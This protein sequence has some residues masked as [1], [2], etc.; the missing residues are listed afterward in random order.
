MAVTKVRQN[1]AR[2]AY[3]AGLRRARSM[4]DESHRPRLLLPLTASTMDTAA[5]A[6][7]SETNG[8]R[9]DEILDV[10]DLFGHLLLV[11]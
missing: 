10:T 8:T 7:Q 2:S 5:S 6:D 1:S 4:P 3:F 11:R 9:G